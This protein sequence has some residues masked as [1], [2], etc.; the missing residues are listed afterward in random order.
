MKYAL[1]AIALLGCSATNDKGSSGTSLGD[2]GGDGASS[3]DVGT[4]LGG[5]AGDDDAACAAATYNGKKIPASLLVL[6]DRSASMQDMGKWDGAVAALSSALTTADDA[7]PVGLLFFPEGKFN[8]SGL[9]ACALNPAAAGCA[10][11]YADSG[12]KDVKTTPDI[13]VAPL[14]T[15]RAPITA[16]LSSTSPTGDT[17]STRWGLKNAWSIMSALDS[18][19]DRF[20]VLVTDGEPTTHQPKTVVGPLMIPES[21]IECSDEKTI[22]DETLA[23]ATMATPV[24]TFVI[25]AP[26]SEK[27]SAFLSQ[28]AINGKTQRSPTCSAAKGDCH[29]QIGSASFSTDLAKA[30]EE[31]TGKIATCIFEVPSGTDVDPAKV[32]VTVDGMSLYRDETHGDGWD[33]TDGSHTKIELHGPAC[34][35][36]KTGASAGIAVKILLGCKTLV[37]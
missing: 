32:N 20:V 8:S 14:S 13:A 34:D 25:G 28:V 29:Y 6:L 23:A 7:L 17:T 22:E 16:K 4:G 3:F 19:G 21:A 27:G 2:G 24:K 36:V 33:Y 5:E 26:G 1:F 31:I 11:L 37:R 18:K 12:C 35:K 9:A 15:S 30:L 10:A